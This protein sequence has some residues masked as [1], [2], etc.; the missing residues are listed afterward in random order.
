MFRAGIF[1]A[2]TFHG[3]IFHAGNQVL[4]TTHGMFLI[5]RFRPANQVEVR[6]Q[7]GTEKQ[8]SPPACPC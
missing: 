2:G 7:T 5:R 8:A 6:A 4:E 1:L 3:G